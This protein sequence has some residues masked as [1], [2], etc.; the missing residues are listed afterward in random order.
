MIGWFAEFQIQY[1]PRRTIKSQALADFA[2]KLNSQWT[3]HVDGSSNNKSCSA[4]VM[5]ELLEQ[6]L[7]FEFKTS[8]NQ[9]EYEA[10]IADLNLT[11]DLEVKRLIYKSESQLVVDQLKGEFE[12]KESLL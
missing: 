2:A 1:Q 4:R 9:V 11:L 5:L 3:L 8:N 7:K 12:I 10:I 6:A